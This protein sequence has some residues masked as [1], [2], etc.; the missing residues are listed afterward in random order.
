MNVFRC[1]RVHVFMFLRVY[2]F[3][4]VRVYVQQFRRHTCLYEDTYTR[5]NVNTLIARFIQFHLALKRPEDEG[6]VGG[7]QGYSDGGYGEH[8]AE[9]FV[10]GGRVVYGEAIGR[11]LRGVNYSRV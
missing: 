2:V 7:Y 1:L 3:R 9:G 4:C 5:T 6:G 10:G 11:C 8:D